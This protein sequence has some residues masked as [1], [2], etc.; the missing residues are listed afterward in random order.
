MKPDR[1]A[2]NDFVSCILHFL[3][4]VFEPGR[5]A[6]KRAGERV[7][8]VTSVNPDSGFLPAYISTAG[9]AVSGKPPCDST[10]KNTSRTG[11][12]DRLSTSTL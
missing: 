8:N 2:V 4:H 9:T 6:R 5:L 11:R 12:N 10:M 1:A 3:T 7:F